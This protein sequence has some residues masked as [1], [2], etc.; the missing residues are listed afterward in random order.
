MKT[1]RRHLLALP[2]LWA[3][4]VALPGAACAHGPTAA[5]PGDAA[6]VNTAVQATREAIRQAV[7]ARD[8]ARL[9]ALYA[10]AF[11][12]TH[13]SGKVDGRPERIV[14]LLTAEP[15]IEMAPVADWAVAVHTG[16]RTAVA[17]GTA[18]ILNVREQQYYRFRWLQVYVREADAWTLAASQATRLP[19]APVPAGDPRA[20]ALAP[21]G[22]PKQ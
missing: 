21:L 2:P 8:A 17:R 16:G 11:T 18:P 19:D 22:T 1:N 9:Q 14:S 4:L 7:L 10:P 3:L 5:E 6:A 15:T 20:A 13:G 12:H